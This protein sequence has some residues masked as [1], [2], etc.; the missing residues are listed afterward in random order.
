MSDLS[1][2]QTIERLIKEAI[3]LAEIF[4]NDQT[5]SNKTAAL[6]AVHN[7]VISARNDTVQSDEL[8]NFKKEI[9][10]YFDGDAK[11]Q[12]ERILELP[13]SR[14]EPKKLKPIIHNNSPAPDGYWSDDSDDEEK[15]VDV[16]VHSTHRR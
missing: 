8:P 9:A 16:L 13:E 2:K 5:E 6:V 14:N 3:R 12:L 11:I 7:V 10:A 4:K 1:S 15:M